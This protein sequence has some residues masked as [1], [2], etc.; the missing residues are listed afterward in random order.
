MI[1]PEG[2]PLAHVYSLER[3][4]IFAERT[5]LRFDDQRPV[6]DMTNASSLNHTPSCSW[7]TAL[8]AGT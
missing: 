6:R 3:M 1:C 8:V 7:I 2:W 5:A 4:V